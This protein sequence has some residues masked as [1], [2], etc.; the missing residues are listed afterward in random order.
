MYHIIADSG[1]DI[2]KLGNSSF[3]T[4]P[5][6]I[7]T[8]KD[9][10]L[11]DETLDTAAMIKHMLAYKGRSYTACPTTDAWLKAFDMEDGSVPDEL[12]IVTLTSGLSGTYNSANVA[13]DIYLEHHP[14]V[15]AVVIDSLSVG[16]EMVV[17]LEKIAELKEAGVEFEE[18]VETI[19][20]Y[21]KKTRLFF[22]FQS[23]H[24]LAQ[25]GRVNK[26]VAAAAGAL[27]ISVYGT[28]SPEGEIAQLGKARGDNRVTAALFAEMEKAGYKGGK[29]RISQVENEQIAE[30]MKNTILK[31]YPDADVNIYPVRGLCSYYCERGGMCLGLETE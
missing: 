9:H 28:A 30:K 25:N 8:D 11:D 26:V 23:L 10:F 1:C 13:K 14:G 17:I 4:V 29:V 22:A 2:F 12:Y 27:G 24:N 6:T 5:L 21:C 7:S 15:K 18:V 16:P 19:G 3:A 20:A 31:Q